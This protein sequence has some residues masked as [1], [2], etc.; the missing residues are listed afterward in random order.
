[1]MIAAQPSAPAAQFSA[2]AAQPQ[3]VIEKV[4]DAQQA[5]VNMTGETGILNR[6]FSSQFNLVFRDGRQCSCRQSSRIQN[7]C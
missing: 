5:L 6:T 3:L 1:M 2:L 4:A 7:P